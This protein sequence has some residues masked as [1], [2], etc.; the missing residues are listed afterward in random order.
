MAPWF[1]LVDAGIALAIPLVVLAMSRRQVIPAASWPLLWIGV[2]IGL[3]WELTFH[4]AGPTYAANPL[5]T[6][7][8]PFPG[9]AWTQP[10]LHAVWDGGFLVV[11]LAWVAWLLPGPLLSRF[12]LGELGIMLVWGQ[13][14]SVIIEGFAAASDAW[15]YTDTWWNPV[16]VPIGDGGISLLPQLVWGFAPIPFYLAA[17][18][19]WPSV[20]TAEAPAD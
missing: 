16:I 12:N 20:S 8:S 11:G 14:Q 1:F 17:L 3:T 10:L 18:R 13:V 9:P 15:A 4:F 2:A 19:I 5:Y 6:Q 7:A